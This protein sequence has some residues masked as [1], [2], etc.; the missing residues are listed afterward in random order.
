MGADPS[1]SVVDASCR[2]HD[3]DNLFV[4]DASVF[5]SLPVMNPALTVA[6]NALRVADEIARCSRQS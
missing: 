6:A 1:T 4:V 3:V 2:A 5:P